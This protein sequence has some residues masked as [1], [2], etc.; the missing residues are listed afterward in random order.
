MRVEAF[1]RPHV[2]RRVRPQPLA[3]EVRVHRRHRQHAG[4][5]DAVL[6]HRLVGQEQLAMPLAHRLLGLAPDALD[7]RAQLLGAAARLEGAV[8]LGH[9]AAEMRLQ[10][11]PVRHRQHRRVEHQ[12][13]FALVAHV[14]D[15]GEVAEPGLEAHHVPLAQA[16]DRRVGD[17]AEVLAEELADEPRLVADDGER[18]VVAHRAD[19]FLARLDHRR[20]DQ[21]HVLHRQPG[22]DLAPRQFGPRIA[23]DRVA[24]GGRQVLQRV[25][26]ADHRRIVGLAGDAVLHRAIV[27]D[28]A[29][30]EIDRDH[31]PRPEPP[32]GDDAALGHRH[33]AALRAD[34]QQTVVGAGIAQRPQRVAVHPRHRPAAVGHHQ[35]G[36]A[37]PR[38]HDAGEILV[39]RRMRDGGVLPHRFRHQHQLGGRRVAARA[40]DRLEHRVE[41]GGV[42]RASGDHRLDVL[43]IVA[44]G[45]ARHA[46]LVAEH[47]VAVAADGVDLAVVGE[48]AERL[49]Q[50]PLREGVGRVTLVEQ[51]DAAL[52]ARVGQVGVEDRQALGEEQPLVDD[53]A[54]RQRADVEALDLG[55]DHPLLDAAAD[56]IQV[57]LELSL[58]DIARQW[59]GDH[60]LLDLGPRRLR[61]EADHRHV[62]RHLPPAIDGV[63]RIDDRALDDGAAA[64]LRAEVGAR[65]EDHADGEPVLAHLV[66]RQRDRVV[67]EAQ[68]QVDVEAG[69]VAGLAIGI[70]R[71]AMPHR[72]QRI[73]RRLDDA[74]RRNAVGGGDEAHA[75]SVGLELGTVH[76][77]ASEAGALVRRTTGLVGHG[78]LTWG[79]TGGGAP[80]PLP[81]GGRSLVASATLAITSGIALSRLGVNACIACTISGLIIRFI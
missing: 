44:E 51:R 1:R 3:D 11:R 7:R 30:R 37:I 52:E 36:G 76:A 29:L 55:G 69:A 63:A 32:L 15:V 6:V 20:Q 50:P 39:H 46:D 34:D 71:A 24:R 53:R 68:R 59:A 45:E 41:R 73:D 79:M 66:P 8:D 67:E 18:R 28:H 19:R 42:A 33:H 58:V 13:P 70:D 25:E 2:D 75:A 65:Q 61:L 40:A 62:D 64:L 43:R 31:L 16:V 49:R 12:H 78:V 81:G 22:G 35:R 48:A 17:L 5:G 60:D 57:L 38:L 9:R 23:R 26:L 47:P 72:L 27:E 54:A 14:E 21:L 77:V 80:L 4:D 56:E 10:P 74:P